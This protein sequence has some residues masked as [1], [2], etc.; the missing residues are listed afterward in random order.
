MN[1]GAKGTRNERRC[2]AELKKLGHLTWRVRRGKFGGNDVF[3]RFDILSL[4]NT[5]GVMYLIQVKSNRVRKRD[6]EKVF[7]L[8]LPMSCHPQ[9]WI[10]VDRKGWRR[11]EKK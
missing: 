5:L 3:D 10:W 9:I 11:I 8:N 1:A 2:E 6:R 4:D 7:G